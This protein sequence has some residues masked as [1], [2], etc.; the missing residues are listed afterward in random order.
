MSSKS[1]TTEGFGIRVDDIITTPQNI[2]KLLELAPNTA[3]HFYDWLEAD[4]PDEPLI[5]DTFELED[6]CNYGNAESC[7]DSIAS[8][9]RDVIWEVEGI[10]LDVVV[11][12]SHGYSYLLFS[13]DYPW[14]YPEK[15]R[16]MTEDN[17]RAMFNRYVA[18]L[19]IDAVL[20]DYRE[21]PQ[22]S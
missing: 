21:I 10:S 5:R 8:L 7:D 9:L 22:S 13:V 1:W 20:V 11:S 12:A 2:R 15:V 14:K 3:K 4:Y 16:T 19:D 6:V 18:I 17:M